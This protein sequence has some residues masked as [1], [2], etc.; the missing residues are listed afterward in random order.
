[1]RE[2][3]ARWARGSPL[4]DNR[5]CKEKQRRQECGSGGRWQGG[6]REHKKNQADLEKKP[7]VRWTGKGYARAVKVEQMA[8]NIL[9]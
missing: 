2:W 5:Q 4:T 8:P 3:E 1:M 6:G 7:Q 9:R